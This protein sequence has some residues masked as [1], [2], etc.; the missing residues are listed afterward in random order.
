VGVKP[1]ARKSLIQGETVIMSA[2]LDQKAENTF[3]SRFKARERLL[4]SFIKTPTVHAIE[5]LGGLNFDFV[6]IDEEHAPFNRESIDLALLAA[7]AS[8]LAGIV[9]VAEAS[10]TAILSVLD[11]GAAGVLVPHVYSAAKAKEV[12]SWS[13]YRGGKRGYSGSARAG[14]YGAVPV[15]ANVDRSDANATVIAMIEDP[16]AIDL[17]DEILAVDGIDGV[18]IGRGDLT[19]AYGVESGA[20]PEIQN[21]VRKVSAA[22]KAANKP[23]CILANSSEEAKPF[24]DLGA[25]AFIISSDQG[26]MRKAAQDSLKDFATLPG[27]KR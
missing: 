7:R 10:P 4:G 26:F 13:K 21:A 8:N 18:F 24:V 3:R 12:V 16:P 22:A 1:V 11:C 25:S 5:I 9:R 2:A 14:G 15:W 20:A 19:V 17:I 27:G 6:V 23:V